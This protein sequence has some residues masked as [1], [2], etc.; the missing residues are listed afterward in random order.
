VAHGTPAALKSELGDGLRLELV[1]DPG[2]DMPADSP[3]GPP[4]AVG[5]RLFVEVGADDAGAAVAWARRLTGEGVVAEF[6]L[7]PAS[8]EDVYVKETAHAPVLG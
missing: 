1:L 7:G 6:F 3:F 2:A 8:L 5:R 4:V